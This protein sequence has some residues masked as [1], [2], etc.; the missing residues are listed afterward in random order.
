MTP[1]NLPASCNVAIIGSGPTGLSAAITLRK[2]GIE[3][4]IVIER[5]AVAG[6]IPRHCG[7]PPFGFAAFKR[8]LTGPAYARRIV[9]AAQQEGVDIFLKTTVTKIEEQGRLTL[10]TP[11]GAGN[12][13]AQRVLLATGTRETPRSARFVGGKRPLG[14]CNTGALQS[15]VY[16]KNMIPFRRPLIVGTEIVSFSAL[17]TCK[18]AGIRPVAMIE[19]N[20]KPTVAWPIHYASTFFGVPLKLDTS[21]V[22]ISGDKRVESVRIITGNGQEEELECDGVLFT[23]EFTP[24]SSLARISHLKLDQ[25]TGSPLVDKMGRCSDPTYF[26]AGNIIFH[27]VKVAGKCWQEGARVSGIITDELIS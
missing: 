11:Q 18:N 15:M 10:L 20:A 16:L 24:E 26:S 7:H 12:L 4:V 1:N 27:P 9:Q 22:S 2:A 14:I 21:I 25:L 19:K 3:Q 13:T 6:G 8:I 23:G 5:E 17:L